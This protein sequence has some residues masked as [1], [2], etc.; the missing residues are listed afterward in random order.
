MAEKKKLRVLI[1]DGGAANALGIIRQLG[2]LSRFELFIVAHNPLAPSRFSKFC[3]RSF[4]ISHP[5]RNTEKFCNEISEIIAREKIDF[6]MPV[7]FYSHKAI[8][9]HREMFEAATKLCLPSHEAFSM[10]TSK[11]QTGAVATSAGVLVPQ[12]FVIRNLDEIAMLKTKFPVVIKSQNEIGGRM[13]AYAHNT[14]Q[15]DSKFR[16]LVR[17]HALK[18]SEYPII[19]EFIEGEGVGFF[20]YYKNGEMQAQFMHERIREFPVSGGRSVCARSFSDAKLAKSGKAVLDALKWNGCAMVEF[21]RT[22]ASD[23]YLLEVNPKL[24]GSLELAICSGV[25]FPMLMIDDAFHLPVPPQQPYRISL[26]F[27]WILNGELYYLVHRPLSIFK[28]LGTFFSSRKDFWFTDIR[29]NLIQVLLIAI[30]LKKL[31]L[32]SKKR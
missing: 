12:T 5:N 19:Q 32:P 17:S 27:Q 30:D 16:E 28:I 10:A 31:V 22:S 20:A 29:P 1:T 8:I 4:I 6:L 2:K 13:V 7:G 23:Y 18:P 14:E 21:K 25:N 11:V 26:Y 15:L 3:K 9:G 24:W